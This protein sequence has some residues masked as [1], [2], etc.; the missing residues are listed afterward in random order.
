MK[1]IIL[2]SSIA[3]L[4][5]ACSSPIDITRTPG[6][7]GAPKQ[8]IRYHHIKP[9]KRTPQYKSKFGNPAF[10][11]VDRKKYFTLGSAKGYRETGIASWYGTQFHGK[12]TSSREPYDMLEMTAAHKT[13]PLPTYA[14]VTNLKNGRSIIVKIN[15][16]G[17]FVKDRIIDLSYGAAVKLGM[18]KA[19]T[20]PVEV[21]AIPPF[22][23]PYP[24]A[25]LNEH[26]LQLASFRSR[27]LAQD[28]KYDVQLKTVHDDVFIQKV[29]GWY[30]VR[31]GPF[32]SRQELI[33]LQHEL[34][35]KGFGKGMAIKLP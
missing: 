4:L 1:N 8:E 29:D 16:R 30:T 28:L 27:A 33:N 22:A 15:D 21:V 2:L 9:I 25:E 10:Y 19:G 13:L 24:N 11:I 14:R 20:A 23:K 34:K 35:S 7:D 32:G 6:K 17:P 5:S 26:F 12:L 31:I 18:H 3:Y